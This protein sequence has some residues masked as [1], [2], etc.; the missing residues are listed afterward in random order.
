MTPWAGPVFSGRCSGSLDLSLAPFPRTLSPAAFPSSLCLSTSSSK[1]PTPPQ[2]SV[3]HL[4][5]PLPPHHRPHV[6]HPPVPAH[7]P[8]PRGRAPPT[9]PVSP[10]TRSP[11][12]APRPP[13]AIARHRR[14]LRRSSSTALASCPPSL[15]AQRP[16][17][18]DAGWALEQLGTL[19]AHLA[20][21]RKAA[22]AVPLY[23]RCSGFTAGSSRPRPRAVKVSLT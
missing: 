1:H 7:H 2:R 9:L 14:C 23:P 15:Q 20:G 13:P 16:S 8:T 11:A 17:D 22:R 21:P 4:L 10:P 18:M 19:A 5:R 3:F 6:P 12:R